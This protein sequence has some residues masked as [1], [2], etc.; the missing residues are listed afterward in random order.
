MAGKTAI[1]LPAAEARF[2][3]AAS[4]VPGRHC[5]LAVAGGVALTTCQPQSCLSMAGAAGVFRRGGCGARGGKGCWANK[6]YGQLMMGGREPRIA[7]MATWDAWA[8]AVL[9]PKPTRQWQGAGV[10]TVHRQTRQVLQRSR[11][12]AHQHQACLSKVCAQIGCAAWQAA[13]YRKRHNPE[14]ADHDGVRLAVPAAVR[15]EGNA[16]GGAGLAG[17]AADLDE[18]RMPGA[19]GVAWRAEHCEMR[20]PC[21]QPTTPPLPTLCTCAFVFS[22]QVVCCTHSATLS[23]HRSGHG[24]SVTGFPGPRQLYASLTTAG[25]VSC[26]TG[27]ARGQIVGEVEASWQGLSPD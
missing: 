12:G 24:A 27:S 20:R 14:L 15:V 18:L 26:L 16:V 8:S 21:L 25:A 2:V 11:R 5:L 6:A 17:V 3:R 4:S 22:S 7:A 9:P 19:G 1:S 23:A 10:A 13:P